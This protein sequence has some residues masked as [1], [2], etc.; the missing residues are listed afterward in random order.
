MINKKAPL[1][2][3]YCL[4]APS[5]MIYKNT[6]TNQLHFWT[7]QI[8][9]IVKVK[10]KSTGGNSKVGWQSLSSNSVGRTV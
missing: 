7:L 2:Y 9:S 6:P 1:F 10:I 5:S 3:L 8:Q 4:T